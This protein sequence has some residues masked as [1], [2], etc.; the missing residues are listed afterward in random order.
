MKT[1]KSHC[2]TKIFHLPLAVGRQQNMQE[3]SGL[4]IDYIHKPFEL[5]GG[6]QQ[7]VAIA[8][9]LS[10]TLWSFLQMNR[11]ATLIQSQAW[12]FCRSLMNCTDK[13]KTII[14]VTHDENIAKRAERTIR[15]RDGLIESNIRNR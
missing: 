7:R 3:K 1:L 14:M 15:L 4:S 13:E 5:S 12:K 8:G 11:Q 10:T 6:Q 9:R 2:F